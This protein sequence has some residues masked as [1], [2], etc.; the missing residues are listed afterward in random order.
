MDFERGSLDT[1]EDPRD[2]AARVTKDRPCIENADVV[3]AAV[4]KATQAERGIFMLLF[5]LFFREGGNARRLYVVSV[6]IAT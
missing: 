4:T 1:L 6:Q 3:V 2:A 5:F